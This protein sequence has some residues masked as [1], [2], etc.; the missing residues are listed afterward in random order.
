[1]AIQTFKSHLIAI[2]AGVSDTFP[3]HQWDELLPQTILTLNLLCKSNVSLNISAYSYHHGPFDYNQIPIAPMGCAVQFH[4][5][6]IRKKT[7][8]EH[9]ADGW[10]LRTS[11][12]HYRYHVVFVKATRSKQIT[13]TVFFKHKYITQ[14]TVTPANAIVKAYHDLISAI[15]GIKNTKSDSHLEA[16]EWIQNNL[17]PGN[18]RTIKI[19][20]SRCPRVERNIEQQELT[21][22]QPPRVRFTDAPGINQAPMRMIVA[23]PKQPVVT[24]PSNSGTQR[25]PKPNSI[26]KD[27]TIITSESIADRVKA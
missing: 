27:L 4:I 13:D 6:P 2:L 21:D 14:P 7:F 22:S 24:S 20:N 11:P 12:E 5:K 1:K 10:Y 26:L 23:S 17:A 16:L 9:S 15:N 3:I 25:V 19:S 18:E 8:G